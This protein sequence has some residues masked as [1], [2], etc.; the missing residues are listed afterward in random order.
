MAT[1]GKEGTTLDVLQGAE[2]MYMIDTPQP[3]VNSRRR[4]QGDRKLPTLIVVA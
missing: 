4:F 2:R 3:Y 1:C